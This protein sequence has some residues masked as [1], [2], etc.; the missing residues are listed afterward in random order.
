MI[1]KIL[2]ILNSPKGMVVKKGMIIILSVPFYLF[3]TLRYRRCLSLRWFSSDVFVFYHTFIRKE[4][5]ISIELDDIKYIIDAGANTGLTTLYFN[6]KYPTSKIIAI[7]PEERNYNLLVK[8]TKNIKS[9]FPLKGGVWNKDAFLKITNINGPSWSFKTEEVDKNE[10]YDIQAFSIP[11]LLEK[12]NFTIID[13]L[14]I[15]IEGA[16]KE[17]FKTNTALWLPKTK[18]LVIELHGIECE[19]IVQQA[20]KK[21]RFELIYVNGENL[22][23]KNSQL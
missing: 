15:D 7:E 16:E 1:S 23:Y 10:M 19:R 22:Y 3:F 12:Y 5:S 8:N 2:K 9:I 11:T 20:L 13:L 18:Y 21:Y 17:L 4:F 14:V 6:Y